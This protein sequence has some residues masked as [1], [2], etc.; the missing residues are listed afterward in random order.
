MDTLKQ[1]NLAMRYIEANL[2]EDIDFEKVAQLA[3]CSQYH[4]RRM[5]SFLVGMPVTEYI[6]HRRLSLAAR[7]LQDTQV[8]V[9]DLA[10]KY[11]YTSADAFTRAFQALHGLTPTEARTAGVSLKAIPPISFQLTIYG[12]HEMDYRI[13]IKEAFYIVGL[14]KRIK[15]I[16]EGVNPEI[17]EMVE[18]LTEDNIQELKSLSNMEPQG[19]LNVSANFTDDR[20]EGSLLDQIIGVATTHPQS[21]G[22]FVLPVKAS[23]WAVFTIRGA[24]PNAL[25]DT[26]ARI[27]TEWF[28]MVEYQSNEGPSMVWTANKD[29]P[30]TD[31]HNELWIPIIKK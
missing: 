25:Q 21:E 31:Y 13:V 15:L 11:G 16:Y 29:M 9:I 30:L 3:H 26:W 23:E 19:L 18:S 2:A 28:P 20:A 24:F 8:R 10:V 4:F 17:M 7:E 6:R 27:Y 5:F 12:G 1:L 22:W 14:K